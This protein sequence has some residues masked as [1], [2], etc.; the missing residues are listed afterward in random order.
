MPLVGQVSHWGGSEQKCCCFPSRAE[1]WAPGPR[2]R[3]RRFHH[4]DKL[5]RPAEGSPRVVNLGCCPQLAGACPQ[6]G[7]DI[8]QA[9]QLGGSLKP[10]GFSWPP[11]LTI[12]LHHRGH[13]WHVR[14]SRMWQDWRALWGSTLPW[15]HSHPKSAV[16]H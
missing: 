10:R 5:V 16:C 6:G 8:P 7:G 15:G 14:F 12:L 3:P 1:H 9:H 13:L 2:D 4:W 11:W